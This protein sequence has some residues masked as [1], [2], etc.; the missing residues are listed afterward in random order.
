[1]GPVGSLLLLI[2]AMML[3]ER[4]WPGFL[5]WRRYTIDST[6]VIENG[7]LNGFLRYLYRPE[8]EPNRPAMQFDLSSLPQVG[9]AQARWWPGPTRSRHY[10]KTPKRTVCNSNYGDA[11]RQFHHRG[12]SLGAA[13]I[14]IERGQLTY[15]VRGITIAGNLLDL[16]RAVDGVG[17]DWRFYG[18]RAAPSL[19]C[20]SLNVAGN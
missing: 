14:L 7:I 2:A 11:H 19:R 5:R 9:G 6:T 10:G 1:M 18:S 12:F 20:R 4:G 3:L 16:L 13:G 17:S 15:P 8:V